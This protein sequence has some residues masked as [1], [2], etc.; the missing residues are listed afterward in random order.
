MSF[1]YPLAG[2][3][4]D[5]SQMLSP[6]HLTHGPVIHLDEYRFPVSRASATYQ[7]APSQ[8]GGSWFFDG[9]TDATSKTTLRSPKVVLQT[10]PL[11]FEYLRCNEA[12]QDIQPLSV[13]E[14]KKLNRRPHNRSHPQAK[15]ELVGSGASV[16]AAGSPRPRKRGRKPRKQLK[17]KGIAGQIVELNGQDLHNDP[18]R[19]RVQERN[20]IAAAKCRARK[21]DEASALASLAED[22]EDQNRHLSEV[23]DSAKAEI[24]SL[25]AQMLRHTHCNCV[26]IQKY[27]AQEAKN[28]VEGVFARS[29]SF[30]TLDSSPNQDS[31][32][33][34]NASAAEESDILGLEP[35]SVTPILTNPFQQGSRAPEIRDDTFDM[36]LESLQTS[37]I[38]PDSMT[39]IQPVTTLSL[40]ECGLGQYVNM[41]LQEYQP[42][43]IAWDSC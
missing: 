40:T 3:S 32:S 42:N 37:A 35:H 27:I 12:P 1:A 10:Q 6:P 41:E 9:A 5:L 14:D 29:S 30:Y 8:I 16:Q 23:V 34:T 25:K 39:S 38:P 33:P 20:R 2:R 11:E 4:Y 22:M 31:R 13:L 7:P 28:C 26:L 17:E 19:R 18:R 21:A 15:T 24:Y 43:K 36:G